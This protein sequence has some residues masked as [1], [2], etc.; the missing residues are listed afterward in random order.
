MI[1]SGNTYSLVP[2]TDPVDIH[3]C[4]NVVVIEQV[5]YFLYCVLLTSQFDVLD[6]FTSPTTSNSLSSV[7]VMNLNFI[8]VVL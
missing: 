7:V 5:N 6:G 8:E 1:N 3:A 2:N 4:L